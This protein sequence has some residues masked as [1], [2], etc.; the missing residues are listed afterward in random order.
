MKSRKFQA[1]QFKA[2]LIIAEY[3]SRS[4]W[5]FTANSSD[6]SKNR[7]TCFEEGT[8]I[9]MIQSK[10]GRCRRHPPY[11]PL[12]QQ[13]CTVKFFSFDFQSHQTEYLLRVQ[14]LKCH[15]SSRLE[16]RRLISLSIVPVLRFLKRY[17]GCGNLESV[18]NRELSST[19]SLA[20]QIP[21]LKGDSRVFARE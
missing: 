9:Q 1:S 6:F 8:Y 7:R 19:S 20:C 3:H 2:L 13:T 12:K 4:L 10:N 17:E 16:I 11:I 18:Q 14:C 21:Y 5:N 15:L